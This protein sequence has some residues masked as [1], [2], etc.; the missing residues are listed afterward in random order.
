MSQPTK[1]LFTPNKQPP[2][3]YVTNANKLYRAAASSIVHTIHRLRSTI[4]NTQNAKK[5]K[6]NWALLQGEGAVVL[7]EATRTHCLCI[8]TCTHLNSAFYARAAW[9]WKTKLLGK[10]AYRN[11]HRHL[12][13]CAQMASV[14]PGQLTIGANG[15]DTRLA[16]LRFGHLALSSELMIRYAEMH[17]I[18]SAQDLHTITTSNCKGRKKIDSTGTS[19]VRWEGTETAWFSQNNNKNI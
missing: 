19:L 16:D 12:M 10:L 9:S 2:M 5:Y 13:T 6:K 11:G 4:L 14:G 1:R 8:C 7:N 15:H 18:S 17:K 3:G